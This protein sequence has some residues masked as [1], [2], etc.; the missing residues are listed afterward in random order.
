VSETTVVRSV[1][2]KLKADFASYLTATDQATRNTLALRMEMEHLAKAAGSLDLPAKQAAAAFDAEAK[3]ATKAATAATTAAAGA[4]K[5]A[6]ASRGLGDEMGKTTKATGGFVAELDKLAKNNE[7]KFNR[8]LLGV[9]GFGTALLGVFAGAVTAGYQFDKQMSAVNA[10]LDQTG[11]TAK[12]SAAE[13]GSL[14]DAA[15]QAGKDTIYSATE[16]AKAEEELAKAGVSTAD[17]LGGALGGTLSLASAGTLELGDAATYAARAMNIFQLG[18]KDVGHIADVLAAGANKSAADVKTLADAMSQ[19]GL[20]AHNVGLSL[21]DTVGVLSAFADN[22]LVGSDA[23]TSLKAMFQALQSPSEKTANLMQQ[24]GITLYDQQGKFIGIT[25]FADQLR[26]SLGGLTQ[27]QRDAALS[28][29]FGSDATRAATVIYNEGARGLQEYITAV[30]DQGAAT[31]TAAKKLDNLSGDVEQLKGSLET[32]AISSDSGANSAMRALAQ[33]ANSLV[34]TFL[35]LPKPIQEVTV[36]LA[37]FVGAGAIAGSGFLKAR[38][39]VVEFMDTLREIGPAGEKAAGALGAIGKYAGYAGLAVGATTLLYQGLKAFMDWADTTKPAE[40]NLDDLSKTLLQFANSGKLTGEALK[41]FGGDITAWGDRVANVLAA[42][43]A[44]KDGTKGMDENA[45]ELQKIAV[46]LVYGVDDLDK[47]YRQATE[48]LGKLDEAL[49]Q[50]A[51][52][53]NAAQAAAL[54]DQ[55][56]SSLAAQGYTTDQI[57]ALFAKYET[58]AANAASANT[59]LAKGFASAQAEARILVGS[60]EDAINK[61]EALTDVWKELNGALLGSDEAM[62]SANQALKDVAKSFQDNTK[63]IDG[64]SDAALKNRIAV[65]HAAEEAAKAA[66]AKYEET[67][68]VAEASKVYNDYIDALRKVL[69]QAGLTDKQIDTLLKDYASMPKSITTNITAAGAT[70]AINDGQTLQRIYTDLNG[71]HVVTY[72]SEVRLGK[73]NTPYAQRWGGVHYAAGGLVSLGQAGIYGQG[74][75][76]GFAE[77]ETGG[78]A[79]VPRNGDYARSMAILQT[80]AAWYGA[81]VAPA[82][83]G[84]D[85][86]AAG[87]GEVH[88]HYE[89]TIQPK[90]VSFSPSD[91][92]AIEQRNEVLSRIGR[93]G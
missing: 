21:E 32:L 72:L 91:Y 9:A 45:A 8:V 31:D 7:S 16:A 82:N 58:A 5:S 27:A 15:V 81:R 55:I 88:H 20:V 39:T 65:G 13:L 25:K 48:D 59:G 90:Y 57:N 29:I 26:N 23:G 51:G 67:G 66:Q 69:H 33:I 49:A 2:T 76:Y 30:D 79:F 63:I 44:F 42:E 43:Q 37:G 12:Q 93:P 62:L 18:G 73:S 41:V 14:R 35:D 50:L 28:Q 86:A 34:G 75:V 64:N 10:V 4:D 11:K 1:S 78:E 47:S 84:W 80:A 56:S 40:R 85:G 71:K 54:F 24:L 70:K 36:L 3:A 92:R 68:S 61:G 74:P 89:T 87:G 60:L 83:R 52:N 6:K 46:E 38:K 19:G 17:I 53:G 22:A 77:P